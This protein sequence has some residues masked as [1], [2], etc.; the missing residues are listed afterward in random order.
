M[1]GRLRLRLRLPV[2]L[3]WPLRLR[4]ATELA[5]EAIYHLGQACKSLKLCKEH[6]GGLWI[7]NSD[8]DHVQLKRRAC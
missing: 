7:V 5:L 4:P 2:Q 6:R 8:G 1:G 3:R